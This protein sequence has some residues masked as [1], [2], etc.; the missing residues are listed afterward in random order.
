[1]HARTVRHA[2][3]PLLALV[4]V[5]AAAWDPAFGFDF[6]L[7]GG[8][9]RYDAVSLKSGLRAADFT[10]GQQLKDASLTVGATGIVRLG[11]FEVGLLGEQGRPGRANPTATF[12]ALG[13]LGMSLGRLRLE[14]LG[15]LG[16]QRYADALNNP[17]VIRDTNRAD[18]LAYAGLRPGLSLRL[19]ETGNWLVGLW[20]FARWDL[21][22]KDVHVT[23]AQVS[24]DGRYDLGGSQIGAAARLGFTF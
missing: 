8:F 12:G 11:I 1:M 22:Q 16:G 21:M 2:I 19:G 7:H 6:T 17:A 10:D 3:L 18:W 24:G 15:E 13:G 23:L 14:A 4:A 9:D 5:P 20:A